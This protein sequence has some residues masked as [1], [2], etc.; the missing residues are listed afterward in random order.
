MSEANK[1][2]IGGNHYKVENGLQHWDLIDGYRV[3]YFEGCAS[4]YVTRWDKKNGLEDLKK[5]AHYLRKLYERRAGLSFQDQLVLRPAV[6][7]AV[8]LQ[9]AQANGCGPVET[10]ILGFILRWESTQTIDLARR[11]IE[12][13]IAEREAD[14]GA[15]AS[16]GYVNQDR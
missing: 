11:E 2:Q 7:A 8:I 10:R 14:E 5:A 9:F 15:E 1:I 6:P 4:K 12:R 16:I 13:M 3:G